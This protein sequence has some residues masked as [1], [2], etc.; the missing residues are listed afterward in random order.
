MLKEFYR[1]KNGVHWQIYDR[2]MYSDPVKNKIKRI[3]FY[4]FPTLKF[5]YNENKINRTNSFDI[6]L[7]WF[8]WEIRITRYWGEAYKE[9]M[10]C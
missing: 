2:K 7:I 6:E 1:N 5:N 4:P 9:Q 8:L 3:E 10:E